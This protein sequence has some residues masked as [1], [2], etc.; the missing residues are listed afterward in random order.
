[1]RPISSLR[2][3]GATKL[4]AFLSR[5]KPLWLTCRLMEGS[6]ENEARLWAV[7]R[8]MS[9]EEFLAAAE[10]RTLAGMCGNAT[11]SQPPRVDKPQGKYRIDPREQKVYEALQGPGYCSEECAVAAAAFGRRLGGATQ[12]MQRF[13]QLLEEVKSRR[14]KLSQMAGQMSE[15]SEQA[16]PPEGSSAQ[17][18]VGPG[19][20]GE[21]AAQS[22]LKSVLKKKPALAA[23]TAK[24]PI[25]AAEVKVRTFFWERGAEPARMHWQ[26]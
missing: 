26:P 1:M 25:M 14:R 20:D 22:G 24:T 16:A 17:D 7:A 10:E 19:K 9:G 3:A 13:E 15:L 23:G 4:L 5:T 12:A 2:T 6:F 11:C 8:V 18:A 21:A